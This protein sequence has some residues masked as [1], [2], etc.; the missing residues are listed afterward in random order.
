MSKKAWE[1]SGSHPWTDK[2]LN[3]LGKVLG[4]ISLV[5]ICFIVAGLVSII[6]LI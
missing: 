2:E 5:V 1:E 4:F 6:T 3:H